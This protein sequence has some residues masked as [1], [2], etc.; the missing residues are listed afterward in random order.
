MKQILLLQDEQLFTS[1]IASIAAQRMEFSSTSMQLAHI[2]SQI[3]VFIPSLETQYLHVLQEAF[4]PE[5]FVALCAGIACNNEV[6]AG[7]ILVPSVVFP[8]AS[9]SQIQVQDSQKLSGVQPRFLD[10]IE[11]VGDYDFLQLGITI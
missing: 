11:A 9:L 6:R 4:S 1:C 7:D 5:S 2:D 3:I 10:T 8:L